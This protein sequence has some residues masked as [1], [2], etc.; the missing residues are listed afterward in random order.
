MLDDDEDG[1]GGIDDVDEEFLSKLS[2]KEKKLLLQRLK[3]MGNG[4][5]DEGEGEW[6][7]GGRRMG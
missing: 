1:G 2:T 6:Q 4:Q 5:G 7:G 3:D